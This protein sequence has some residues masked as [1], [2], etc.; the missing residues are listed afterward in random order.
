MSKDFCT[1]GIKA[2][3]THPSSYT[4]SKTYVNALDQFPAHQG[5]DDGNKDAQTQHCHKQKVIAFGPTYA[6]VLAFLQ[7]VLQ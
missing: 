7:A 2:G 4:V 6:Q 1:G 5:V 3:G